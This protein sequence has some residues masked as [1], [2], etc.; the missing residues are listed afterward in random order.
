MPRCRLWLSVALLCL[1]APLAWA[2]GPS[3]A[4]REAVERDWA[5]Q[6][7]AL[8][9]VMGS[10]ESIDAV[11]ARGRA[12][13]FLLR[14]EPA[15][16][17]L[18]ALLRATE[19]TLD[20][21]PWDATASPED[22]LIAEDGWRLVRA[23]VCGAGSPLDGGR[24][25]GHDYTYAG[26]PRSP[27]DGLP[28]RLVTVSWDPEVVIYRFTGLNAKA[29]YRLRAL[30]GVDA[31][32]SL[33][34]AVDGQQ[35]RE[36]V[37][38][39]GTVTECAEALP[40]EITGDG[41]IEIQVRRIAGANAILSGL[42]LWSTEPQCEPAERE[43]L[44]ACRE[45]MAM[46]AP[47]PPDEALDLY[48]RARWAVR[49]LL[50]A[51]PAVDFDRLLFVERQWP[52][53]NHQCAHR[54][55]EHQT[56]GA[57]L[58]ILERLAPDGAVTRLLPSAMAERGGVGRPD[59]SYDGTRIVFPY[60]APRET[61]TPYP[62]AAGHTLYDPLNPADSSGY[63]GGACVMYDLYEIGVDGSGLRQL[64]HSPGSEDTEPCYLPDGRIAFTSSRDG[65][66]VQCGDWA[67]VFGL[68]AMEAD[69]SDP[70]PI[71]E[72]QDTEFFPSVMND[73]RILYT[74]W[75]YVMKAY[76]V[77]QQLW[78]VRPDGTDARLAYGDWYAFSRGPI[79]M[80]EARQ[81][82]GSSKLVAVGAAHHNTGVGPLV[83]A[84]LNLLRAGLPGMTNLTPEV[85]YPECG[86]LLDERAGEAVSDL[87]AI[88]NT[89]N[90]TG[91]YASPWPL[92]ED[93]FL[94][95]YSP[96]DDNTA[97][98]GYGLYLYDRFGNKELIH[99]LPEASCYA[100]IPLRPRP[101]PSVLPALPPSEDDALVYVQNVYEGL[102]GVE[103]GAVRWLRVC[104]TYPKR[105][106]TDPHRVDVGVGS[107][108]DMRG[109]LGMVPVESDG[110]AYMRLPANRMLYFQALDEDLL[111][112]RRMRNYIDLR[113]G[114]SRGC[115]GCHEEP[116]RS[117][118]LGQPMPLATQREPAT[119]DPPPWGA[120]P[121]R[122]E[123]VVQPIL[124]RQCL[125][126]HGEGGDPDLLGG[127]MVVAPHAGDLD[128]GP[129]H[130]V[131]TSFLALLPH[132]E[133]VTMN[134]Y[135]GPKLPLPPYAT[136][137]A[138]SPLMA[139]LRAGHYD[140]RLG[141]DEWHALAAWIDCNAPYYGSYD[142]RIV[143]SA[144]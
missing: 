9:R 108:W 50:F 54:V 125:S 91:W 14:A 47:S 82:P 59:L 3:E 79:T 129:Q 88:S 96:E 37:V 46:E 7:Y 36:F 15:A 93:L 84:D 105:R 16:A 114:E 75:D 26:A 126:C 90:A 41:E 28:T 112:I 121:L 39:G 72:P 143:I 73:G 21:L 136:G 76:N 42:E 24:E 131:S 77:I 48:L 34:L 55:G 127:R 78:S 123:E 57:N 133:Y 45:I 111:E 138:A 80:Q 49:G 115:V 134:G 95:S 128:E 17:D 132:V 137:S 5:R 110:S 40:Q 6:E 116:S 53:G 31:E 74:R 69:G 11:I 86:G 1:L 63:R 140:V 104:E 141:P 22:P 64:T 13:A 89:H 19:A 30:C 43:R 23:A 120:G 119:P 18:L 122:F 87:P 144:E 66:L 142:D 99:R 12:L 67:L 124:D 130:F 58:C 52:S 98:N 135:G 44:L 60:A 65:R 4:A 70:V 83:L 102:D 106:H 139:L 85:G 68:W 38:P 113:P 10:R 35:I 2:D 32:R 107:G 20:G 109:I 81:I 100:P 94:V 8:G 71:T 117:A 56:P 62:W 118:L 61:P 29:E 92:S 33:A 25:R 101:A 51:H 27:A 103:A 97:A